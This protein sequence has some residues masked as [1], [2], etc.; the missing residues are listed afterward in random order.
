MLFVALLTF[1]GA[2]WL[3]LYLL[4]RD[5]RKPLLRRTALGLVSYALALAA[6]L[7]RRAAPAHWQAPLEHAHTLLVFL[8]ALLWGGAAILL[9]PETLAWRERLDRTWRLVLAPASLI[10]LAVATVLGAE[11]GGWLFL[12]LSALVLLPLLVALVLLLWA[13]RAVRPAGAGTLAAVATLFFGLGFAL[14][15]FPLGLLPREPGLLGIGLDLALLGLAVALWDAFEEGEELR[16]DMLRSLLEAEGAALVFGGQ[17]ALAIVLGAGAGL[18]MIAL[19]LTTVAVAVMSQVFSAPLQA[20]LDRLAFPGAAG[21]QEARAQLRASE[22]AL[23]RLRLDP[24]LAALDPEEFARLTRR[25]LSHYGDLARLAASPLTRLPQVDERLAA[26]DAPDQPVERAAELQ[27]LLAECIARLKPRDG[28][29]F[30][31]SD[32]WRYY[33]ALYFPYVVGLRPYRRR[34]DEGDLDPLARQALAWFDAQVPQRTLHNWQNSAARLV[35]QELR[36]SLI[37]EE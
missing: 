27:T 11:P 32:A 25:A 33:N 26:R 21:L 14:L 12:A 20:L 9:L 19:L 7:L 28:G 5:P 15:L 6:D 17:V 4:A 34:G 1:A 18:A 24:E 22:A 37:K 29:A 8:P 2:W 23:P 36:H 3:G 10:A 35:A 16:R 30:G 31:T 13:W